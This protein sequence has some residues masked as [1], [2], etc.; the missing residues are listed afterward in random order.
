M[1]EQ[2]SM[3]DQFLT[4]I[5]QIIEDNIDNEHF[6]VEDLAEKAGLSRSMLHRKLI[7]LTGKSASDH[8]TEIRLTKAK[9][10]LEN[11]VATVSEVA[12]HVGF[13]DP[14]YF[15][16]VFKKHYNVSPGDI[17][18]KSAVN[19]I[20]SDEK[21][22]HGSIKLKSPKLFIRNAIIVF[23]I[24]IIAG[25]IIYL[26]IR[27]SK[28][29]E[30]SLAVLPLDNLT[31]QAENSYFIDGM[32][33]ALIGELGQIKSIRVISRTST[34]RY[35]DSDMLLPD[36]AKE[37]GVNTIVEGSVHCLGDSLCFIIQLIDVFPKERHILANEYKDGIENILMIQSSA[38]KDIAQ[39]IKIKLSKEEEQ[40]LAKSRT[41]DPET[42]KNY[43]QGMYHINKLTPEGI[44]KGLAYLQQAV[45][46]NPDEPLAH[47][48]I[49]IGYFTIAHGSSYTLDIFSK[50]K[51]AAMK[52]LELDESLPEAHLA[53]T[54]V[55]TF[56]NIDWKSAMQSNERAL[57]LNPNLALAR[58]FYGYL[59]RIPGRYE[60]GYAEMIRAKQL[61]PLNPVYSAD[62][63][64]M[65]YFDGKFDKSIEECLKSIE[66]NPEFP[67]AYCTLG[68]AYA[69]KG[70]YK[71]AIAANQKAEQLSVDWKWGLAHTY[72]LA[73]YTDEAFK[74]VSELEK[75]ALPFDTWCI[76]AVYAA[77]GDG[78]KVFYWLEQAYQQH[79]PWI[80]WIGAG[81]NQYWNAFKD[82]PRFKDLA[83]RL[84]LPQ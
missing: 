60:E 83:Q 43:L 14:S 77:L 80:Q 54:M 79:H 30:K 51:T 33:D 12:F 61:D 41:V 17:K 16:K 48:G 23:I 78:D 42:Y 47:A 73:G 15:N 3:E 28:P 44:Q 53:L 32:Q 65:Y 49:A 2:S 74:I 5:N 20:L 70:M 26:I 75:R 45:Q 35:R 38:V 36:I 39:K 57:E 24:I 31:G 10:L 64:W 59:L 72:A 22:I 13:S 46:N 21:Q 67:Q 84:N 55:E 76:S 68:H 9:E 71:K 63:G 82:D 4:L 25:G 34:L 11:D 52:A 1:E 58:Y 7:K 62:L 6:S 19:H 81:K 29:D 37:L 69:A 40:L 56:N 66:I 18:K 8:I 50:V 27:Q